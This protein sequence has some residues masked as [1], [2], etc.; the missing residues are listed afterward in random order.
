LTLALAN[1]LLAET[2]VA[3]IRIDENNWFQIVLR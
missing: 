2:P 1:G 3:T